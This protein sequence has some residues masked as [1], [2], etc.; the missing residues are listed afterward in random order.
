MA[1]EDFVTINARERKLNL[2]QFV[3]DEF[4][5]V[6]K[7]KN[8]WRIFAESKISE[9]FLHHL[10]FEK[11]I[12]AN[13]VGNDRSGRVKEKTGAI[14]IENKPAKFVNPKY[15]ENEIWELTKENWMKLKRQVP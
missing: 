12:F 1:R 3:A 6:R 7:E 10:G 11:L 2:F 13:A 4:K 8:L 5:R 15:T 9:R 14:Y